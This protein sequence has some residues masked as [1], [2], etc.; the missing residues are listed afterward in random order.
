MEIYH[1][2]L[3]GRLVETLGLSTEAAVMRHIASLTAVLKNAAEDAGL[4]VK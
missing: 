3:K 1:S 2:L 4:Q